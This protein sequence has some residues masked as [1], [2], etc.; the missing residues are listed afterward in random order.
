MT[1]H[2]RQSSSR[3]KAKSHAP[4]KPAVSDAAVY[5]ALLMIGAFAIMLAGLLLHDL[6]HWTHVLVGY[7]I[8][9]VVLINLYAWQAYRGKHLQGWQEALARLPM[10]IAGYGRKGGKPLQ[11]AKGQADARTT[12]MLF[13]AGSVLVVAVVSVLL[14]R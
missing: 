2:A 14:I 1:S 7:L 12:L 6:A 9:M 13:G 10:R 5:V 8:A 3:R 4:A 11:A